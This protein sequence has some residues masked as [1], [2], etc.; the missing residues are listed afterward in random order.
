[1]TG[2][3]GYVWQWVG[4]LAAAI[5]SLVGGFFAL[6]RLT[7][8]FKGLG[9]WLVLVAAIAL[10]VVFLVVLPRRY[11]TGGFPDSMLPPFFREAYWAWMLAFGL[12]AAGSFLLLL[13]FRRSPRA[14]V[15]GEAEGGAVPWP[16]LDDA[17]DEI[18][19][20]LEQANIEP[21]DQRV[22]LLIAPD[23]G[24]AA[25]LVRS[26]GLQ[27]FV[28]APGHPAPI[29][30]HATS[31]GVLLSCAGA[32]DL[33]ATAGRAGWRMEALCRKLLALQPDCPV[34]R[35]V[36]V[37]FPIGWASQPESISRAAALREDLLAI[38]RV[39]K[40]R[41]PVFALFPQM[42]T[43]PGF[44]EFVGRL[45]SQVAPHMVDQRVGFAVPSTESFSGELVQG[46]LV[47]MSGW[48][49]SWALNLLAGDPLNDQGNGQIVTLD[50]EIRRYRKRLR[51]LLES[52][53]STHR[54]TEP[55]LFRGSYFAATGE[56]RTER[57]FTAGL[58]RGPRSRVLAD[59]VATTWSDE[60]EWEDRRYG[61]LALA[62]GS[63]GGLIALVTW[64]YIASRT[65][66]GWVGLVAIAIAWAIALFK[67]S[68]Q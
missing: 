36:V 60:A 58:L 30:A 56:G 38:R 46:G 20:R 55:V 5:L 59:H 43:V 18:V 40:V 67:I 66:L 61:R 1:M 25:A 57:A 35:G 28:E 39:L 23:E 10:A 7:K 37:L 12:G 65:P 51:A 52:A 13:R 44:N 6:P 3:T 8:L 21:A 14:A 54:E 47:W 29:H 62:V 27:V 63:V 16:E 34:V 17:W 26:A 32:S 42:E 49:H 50:G 2:L 11:P 19:V 31:D 68:R 45:A 53:F 4:G 15:A 48:F 24:Q 22:T 9:W 33:G 64:L 41:C